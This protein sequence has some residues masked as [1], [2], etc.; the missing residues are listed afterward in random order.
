[1]RT[2]RDAYIE[3]LAACT[4]QVTAAVR[5]P[6]NYS[7]SEN[8][9][10]REAVACLVMGVPLKRPLPEWCIGGAE[11]VANRLEPQP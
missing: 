4:W 7:A 8:A 5:A 9:D 10:A 2:I 6:G 11:A 3:L 1:M